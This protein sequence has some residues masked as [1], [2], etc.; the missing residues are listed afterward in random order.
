MCSNTG[1]MI[2]VKVMLNRITAKACGRTVYAGPSEATA[3]G[4]LLVQMMADGAVSDLKSGRQLV[5]DSFAVRE[6]RP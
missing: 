3:I 6:Y 2:E 1:T 5:F 4:N